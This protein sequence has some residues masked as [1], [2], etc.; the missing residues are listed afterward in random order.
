VCQKGE[1]YLIP[2]GPDNHLFVVVTEEDHHGM[3]ILVNVSSVDA[4][5]P[6]DQTC[7]LNEGDHDF[8][9]RPS[10]VAYEFA[11]QRH[12]NFIDDKAKKKV[13]KKHKDASPKLVTK[14]CCGIKKSPFTKRAI[15]DGYDSTLRAVE[16]RKK[17]K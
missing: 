11:V 10:Y 12:K 14:I 9:M 8:I 1:T 4:T 16:R 7:L 15:K 6:H 3:H 13:Y 2:S 17:D 5:F